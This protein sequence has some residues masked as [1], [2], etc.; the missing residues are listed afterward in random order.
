MAASLGRLFTD[1]QASLAN[2]PIALDPSIPIRL[3]RNRRREFRKGQ[4]LRRG[5]PVCE[6]D[7]RRRYL[8]D[9]VGLSCEPPL[10]RWPLVRRIV[11]VLR[12]VPPS[13]KCGDPAMALRPGR[14]VLAGT[15]RPLSSIPPTATLHTRRWETLT[16]TFHQRRVPPPTAAAPGIPRGAAGAN[17]S[18]QNQR[19]PDRDHDFALDAPDSLRRRATVAGDW[20]AICWSICKPPP[21][22]LPRT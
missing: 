8:N 6:I 14:S 4:L 10:V 20:P 1:N 2:G 16:G 19:R 13:R 18:A 5:R 22:A 11:N 15:G 12:C 17:G 7:R 21:R 9:I 3:R